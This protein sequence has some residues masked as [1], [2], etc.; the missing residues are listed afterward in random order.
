MPVRTHTTA[1]TNIENNLIL[2]HFLLKYEKTRRPIS[3]SFRNLID[4]LANP[5]RASHL[6]HPY[7]AKLLMHIPYFFLSNTILSKPGDIV[8][9]PF[10]GSGTVLLESM[11]WGRN[12]IGVDVNPLARLIS[13]VKTTPI[14]FKKLDAS[15]TR[16]RDRVPDK[17][18][19]DKPDVV[20]LDY[21]FYPH[22][23]QKLLRILEA[24]KATHDPDIRDFFFVCFSSCARRVSLADP[25]LS[26]PVRL[27]NDQYQQGH[28]LY[29][30]TDKHLKR[31]RRINVLAEFEK[32]VETNKIRIASLNSR[33]FDKV[34]VRVV[35]VDAKD[36]RLDLA[37]NG[38]RGRKIP[39]NSVDLIITSPPYIGA[40]KYIRA[41]SLSLGWLDLCESQQLR[42]L[43]SQSI[44]REHFSKQTYV[45][46]VDTGIKEADRVLK[47]LHAVNPLRGCITASYILE[48]R[49]TLREMVRVL[50]PS[51]YMVL[52]VANNQVCGQE[53]RT[54]HYLKKITEELGMNLVLRLVDDI[55]SRGLMTKRNKTASVITREWVLLFQKNARCYGR[56][57]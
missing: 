18:R 56:A 16:L 29:E 46:L 7:P 14:D 45:E 6:I 19:L 38:R 47:S 37:Q 4:T 41:S 8:L 3:V 51:G 32:I 39:A 10:C 33:N 9:D 11:L 15:I 40:Q 34:N 35:G 44:G 36:L 28:W 42:E 22:V 1:P 50:K 25:R 2:Q 27:R 52:V 5:N 12:A 43:E 57:N 54:T 53:F 48:M 21:W 55:R 23:V 20:N 17:S 13:K 30:K 26:V 24:I 49:E 31:L